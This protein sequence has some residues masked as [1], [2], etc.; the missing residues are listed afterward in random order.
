VPADAIST[1]E[2]KTN[3][4]ML[5]EDRGPQ[6][7]TDAPAAPR[8]VE[9]SDCRVCSRAVDRTGIRSVDACAA[10]E[11]PVAESADHAEHFV[12]AP[13]WIECRLQDEVRSLIQRI[14]S[15]VERVEE[16][17]ACTGCIHVEPAVRDPAI[18]ERRLRTLN[19]ESKGQL[20]VKALGH[21]E[22]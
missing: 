3:V 13:A 20:V 14:T 21:A 4:T 19:G 18:A 5:A 15:A 22:A 11:D 1:H 10:G 8:I 9:R 7:R 6:V 12:M 2:V 16:A 17:A